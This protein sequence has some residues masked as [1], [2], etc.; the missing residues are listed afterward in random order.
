MTEALEH[1]VKA[2]QLLDEADAPG[3][4]GAHVDLARERLSRTLEMIRTSESITRQAAG[5][6][7]TLPYR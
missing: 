3:D 4:I 6:S 5:A 7:S 2:L 1:V